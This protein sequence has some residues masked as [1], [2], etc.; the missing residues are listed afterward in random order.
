MVGEA[1][2][3]PGGRLLDF[4]Y[5]DANVF[6]LGGRQNYLGSEISMSRMCYLWSEIWGRRGLMFLVCHYP[7]HFLGINFPFETGQLIIWGF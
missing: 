4:C 2:S 7:N 1:S 5:R 3:Y 6:I